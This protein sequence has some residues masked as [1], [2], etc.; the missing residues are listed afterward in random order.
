MKK[1]EYADKMKEESDSD[2]SSVDTALI[3]TQNAVFAVQTHEPATGHRQTGAQPDAPSPSYDHHRSVNTLNDDD[4]SKSI[5]ID[6]LKTDENLPCL[7][8]VPYFR[9]ASAPAAFNNT[10]T[11]ANFTDAPYFGQVSGLT[12]FDNVLIDGSDIEAPAIGDN[13]L[14]TAIENA[15][16]DQ[17]MPGMIDPAQVRLQ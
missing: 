9:H 12:A 4:A 5:E 13:S 6:N 8:N 15:V 1:E 16:T 3:R 10:D 7:P 17:N 2:L 14:P 11:E